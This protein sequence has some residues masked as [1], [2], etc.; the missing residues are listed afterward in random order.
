MVKHLHNAGYNVVMYDHL[1]QSDSDGGIGKN[2]QGTEAPVGVGTTEW[3]D[4]IASL[5]YIETH[6]NFR[7][8]EI[9]FFSQC[10]GINATFKPWRKAPQLFADS[11]IKALVA[12]QPTVSFN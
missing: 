4:V 8:D 1:G 2:A 9:A 11:Q 10:M 7:N 5:K 3:Q 12:N 6:P